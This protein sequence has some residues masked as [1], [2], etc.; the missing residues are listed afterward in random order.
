QNADIA[1]CG[2]QSGRQPCAA[3][4]LTKR[5]EF[6]RKTSRIESGILFIR[7]FRSVLA[8]PFSRDSSMRSLRSLTQNDKNGA[9][10]TYSE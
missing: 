8:I 5:R 3:A 4:T 1:F 6:N 10:F 7:L 9:T 2:D